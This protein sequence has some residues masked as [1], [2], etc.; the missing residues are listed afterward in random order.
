MSRL[1]DFDDIPYER[2]YLNELRYTERDFQ[3]MMEKK[4]K[5]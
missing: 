4:N 5:K 1:D 3:E 2:E